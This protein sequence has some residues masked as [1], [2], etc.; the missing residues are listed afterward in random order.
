M[1]GVALLALGFA[2]PHI[3]DGWFY[4]SYCSAIG[5]GIAIMVVALVA[6]PTLIGDLSEAARAKYGASTLG[7]VD[8]EATLRRLHELMTTQKL[9]ASEDLSLA[10]LAAAVQ[11]ARAEAHPLGLFSPTARKQPSWTISSRQPLEEQR[12]TRDSAAPAGTAAF[13]SW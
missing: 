6:N 4:H 7:G 1:R 3:D 5:L 13:F 10:S 8:V 2:M 12:A 9:Y 11:P